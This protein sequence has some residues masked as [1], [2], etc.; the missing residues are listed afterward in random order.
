MTIFVIYL[1][2][3]WKDLHRTYH[4]QCIT[5]KLFIVPK[6]GRLSFKVTK[7]NIKESLN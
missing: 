3:R 6:P 4:D 5:P 2:Q 1:K 7:R